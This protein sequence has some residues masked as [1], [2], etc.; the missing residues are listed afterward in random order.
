MSLYILEVCLL[1]GSTAP[2]YCTRNFTE[3]NT[4]STTITIK[5][6]V[7]NCDGSMPIYRVTARS[8][9]SGV[10]TTALNITSTVYL[11]S[12]LEAAT[13]YNVELVDIECQNV[14]LSNLSVMTRMDPSKLCN[15]VFAYFAL[16]HMNCYQ[17]HGCWRSLFILPSHFESSCMTVYYV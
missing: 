17:T 9:S 4:T 10:V 8:M 1:F 11:M 5:L 2:T 16:F 3:L 12:S 15:C 13:A 7:S 14:I 6:A